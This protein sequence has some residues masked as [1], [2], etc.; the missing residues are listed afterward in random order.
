MSAAWTAE[1][2]AAM[3]PD[4]GSAKAGQGLAAPGKWVT[5]GRDERALWGEC[6]GSG[7]KPYQVAV[8]SSGPAFRCSCPS[9]K[10]PCKHA[11][12]L[13]FMQARSAAAVPRAATPEWVAEWIAGRDEKAEK[14]AAR[15]AAPPAEKAPDAEAQAR[16]AAKREER[17]AA[18]VEEL[19]RWLE[20]LVRQGIAALS[21]KPPSFWETPAA[22]LV[23][24]QAP[25]AARLVRQLSSVAH[26]GEG[27]PE[28]MLERL[29][30]LH[31][32][33]EAYARIDALPEPA[34][35]DVRAA[36]GFTLRQ[37]DLAAGEGVRDRWAVLG[38]RVE[39][40]E[41]L[42]VRRIWMRGE[43]TGR[44]ALLL[45]FSVAGQPMEPGPPPG[46]IVEAELAF[47]PGAAPLRA[48]FRSPPGEPR[49]LST[50]TGHA[51]VGDALAAYA[52]ALARNPWTE[53]FPLA[54][55]AVVPVQDGGGWLL[56]DS[57]GAAI[58][59]HPS[60]SPAGWPL[61]A[62]SGGA[63]VAVFGEWDD[64]GL[65]PLSASAGGRFVPLSPRFVGG[66]E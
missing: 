61:L 24:A 54:L 57:D 4:P 48:V 34:R 25:G 29:A 23:D 18:G 63:P 60:A 20:D 21:S 43:S 56:R 15:A 1:Q 28:R 53:R 65:Y 3:A 45:A 9:R 2:V 6:S 66:A 31:L 19:R 47:Y 64:D 50:V 30:R 38:L 59:L 44:A 13:L 39:E 42:T 32:L 62:M 52:D 10:F 17:V 7:A 5:T 11:L 27:W 36:L 16:R 35:E 8:D 26:S 55:A 37:E 49:H 40:E 58:P 51:T 14:Q 33:A 41:R 12:G 22:R 46:T